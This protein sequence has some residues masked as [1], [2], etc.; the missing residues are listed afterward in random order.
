[1]CLTGKY[2]FHSNKTRIEKTVIA[3]ILTR[4]SDVT[5]SGKNLKDDNPINPSSPEEDVEIFNHRLCCVSIQLKY[6]HAKNT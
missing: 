2:V 4:P 5:E 3:R 6:L 1:M